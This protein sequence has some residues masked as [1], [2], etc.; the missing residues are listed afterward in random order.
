MRRNGPIVANARHLTEEEARL[1][2]ALMERRLEH[3][4]IDTEG[5]EYF[6]GFCGEVDG[7][8]RMDTIFHNNDTGMTFGAFIYQKQ[9]HLLAASP[10]YDIV[11]FCCYNK[12]SNPLMVYDSVRSVLNDPQNPPY[13][14]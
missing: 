12:E 6:G 7:T 2:A 3:E 5:W 1:C 13:F 11:P 9:A 8:L 14:A 10:V 4:G